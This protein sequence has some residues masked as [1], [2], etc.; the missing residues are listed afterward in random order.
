[1]RLGCDISGR[2]PNLLGRARLDFKSEVVSLQVDPG[3]EAMMLG[4]AIAKRA[5]TLATM[6]GREL[7][8]KPS[9]ARAAA[10][11]AVG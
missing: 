8:L 3:W 9:P 7:R 11:R 6:L 4:E 5:A 1:M 2:S 10:R